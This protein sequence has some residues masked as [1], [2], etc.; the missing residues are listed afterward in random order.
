MA[1]AVHNG[2]I[3]TA[4]VVSINNDSWRTAKSVWVHDGSAWRAAFIFSGAMTVGNDGSGGY[5]YWAPGPLGSLSSTLFQGTPAVFTTSISY[6]VLDTNKTVLVLEGD[7]GGITQNSYFKDLYCVDSGV[8]L[9]SAS[10]SS[11]SNST[12]AEWK[13][14]GDLFSLAANSGNTLHMQAR[15]A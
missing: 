7:I 3:R 13:W 4:K 14:D 1:F 15:K 9:T 2:A 8:S 5:G 11:F 10:A 12:V 6:N